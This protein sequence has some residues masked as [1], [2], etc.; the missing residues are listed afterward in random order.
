[1]ARTGTVGAAW[2]ALLMVA[3]ALVMAAAPARAGDASRIDIV[4][5]GIYEHNVERFEPEPGHISRERV[6]VTNVTLLRRADEVDAQLGRMIGFQFRVAD[7][8]L[9]GQTITLRRVVPPLTNPATGETSTTI[10]RD[11]VVAHEGQLILN[12]YRFDYDWEMAEGLW[13]FEVVHDGRVIAAK[14]IKVVVA[15]N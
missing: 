7:P 2:A 9:V 12:A 15:M 5:Y 4:D 11:V 3:L 13:R 14:T 10:L 6:I 1:M 8:A